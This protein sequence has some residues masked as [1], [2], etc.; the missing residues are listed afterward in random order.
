MK[1]RVNG[2]VQASTFVLYSLVVATTALG[3][4]TPDNTLGNESSVVTPNVNVNGNLADLIEGGAI[5]ESNLFHSFSDFNVAEMGRVYFGLPAG[6]DNILSRVTGAN[7]SNILGTLGVL[8]NANL[9]LINPNG[10]FFGPNSRLDLGGS[11]FG[12]TADSVLF[13][14]GTVF[15]ALNPNGKPLLTINIPSGLQYG[16]NPG[17]ITNQSFFG[18]EV[19]DDQTLGLIGGEVTIPGGALLAFDGRIELGSVGNGV[20]KL[21][22]T[23]TSFVLDYS[24]VQ[25]FQDIRLSEGALVDTSGFGGGSIQ[26]QGANVSLRG[27]DVFA[28]TNGSGTGGGI[29]VEASQLSLEGGSRITTDVTGSG[30]GGDLTVDTTESVRVIGVAADGIL[31]VLRAQVFPGATGN[32]GDVSITTGELMVSD[33]ARVSAGSF[34]E[35]DGGTLRVDASSTVQVIGTSADSLFPS[36]LFTQTEGTANAGEL[37][38]TTDQLMVSDGAI[39]SASTFGLGDSGNLTVDASSSIQVIGISASGQFPSGLFTQTQGTGHGGDVSITTGELMVSDGARVSARTTAEGDGGNLSVNAEETVQL[40]GTSASGQFASGLFARTQGTGHGGDVSITTGELMVSDGAEVLAIPIGEGDGGNL[41]VDASSTVQVIGTSASGQFPSALSTQTPGTGKAGNL[42]ITT[43]ELMVSD[44]AVVSAGTF[45]E[46]EGGELIV[47]A[48]STVQVIGTSAS[49]EF[50]SGL[51]AQTE[52]TANA[53]NLTITTGE[54]IVKDGAVVSASTSGERN[55]GNLIINASSTVQVIGTSS[56]GEFSSGLFAQTEGTANAKNL[57][58][59]TGELIV[60]DG[61]VVS[62][63]TSGERNGGNLIINASSTVQVIGTSSSGEFGSRLTAVANS[64]SKGNAGDVSITT[65][66][67]IVS[68]G[69]RVSAS[70]FGEGDGGDLIINA[71]ETVQVIGRSASGEFPSSLSARANSDSKGN[72]GDVSITTGELIVSDGARVSASNFAEGNGGNLII[73]AEQ[74]VQVI[75]TSASGEFGSSLSAQANSDSKGNAGHLTITTGELIVKDGA[76]VS[77]ATL[78]EGNGGNLTVDADSTVQLIGITPDDQFPTG[79]FTQ[80][81]ATGDAGELLKITTGQLFIKDG[82]IVSARSTQQGSSAG[83][84]DINANSIFL[85]NGGRIT[86]ETAGDKGNIILEAGDIRLLKESKINTNAQNTDG[87]NITIDTDTLVG[88]GNSDITANADKGSGGRVEIN[89]QGIF[90]LEFRDRETP[91]NDI[92]STSTLGSSFNGQV[93]L[94]VP[95]V[96]PTSGLTELPASPVDAEAILAND[97]CGFENNRI[98]GGSS[99]IITGKGGLPPTPENPVINAHRTVGWR[100]RPRLTNTRQPL[101]QQSL[102]RPRQDKKV[103]I[104]AQG[105]VIAKDGT[106]ILTAQPFNGTPVEQILPNLDCHSG[107]GSRE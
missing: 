43:G 7:V 41:T 57:T 15:S 83:T 6:I 71:E 84:V 77:A 16:S 10:I 72:A 27:S 54:L 100:R 17:S 81:Q 8:G 64:D 98:A 5:R 45:G 38:I 21:T 37:S 55:G 107:G 56:S 42:K 23:D 4:I 1:P 36:G 47:D 85:D 19:P 52:G 63:S 104:E 48:S 46:G 9:F 11:F 61:A 75:G 87:G 90:G 60:K 25:E 78:G 49:G 44:G 24:A 106:I 3:Q 58:I 32:G 93:I 74:T 2:L 18:L 66:E 88:L 86:A 70:T 89:A 31:S 50:S 82:A 40:I 20:V 22:P 69:A 33:G 76:Q 67:L 68:D 73:N 97:L 103:I 65:G 53:K 80:A 79:L 59:T 99:F 26:V 92:T 102:V 12:S 91:D 105:W 51:F 101:P 14:D 94:N 28:D 39:V 95:Q 35:G 96:D 30:Q 34:G 29:V 13:D 62:A